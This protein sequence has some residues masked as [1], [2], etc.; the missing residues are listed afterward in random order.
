MNYHNEIMNL[1]VTV[2]M[3]QI[4]LKENM[5]NYKEGHRD[6]RH[7]AAEIV[8]NADVKIDNMTRILQEIADGVFCD[9]KSVEEYV[10][11]A[12]KE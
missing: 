4:G 12:L 2:N 5:I 11:N 6:A 9:L 8:Q 1:P 3:A 7:A 10:R